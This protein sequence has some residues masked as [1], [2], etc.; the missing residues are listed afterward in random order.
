[1]TTER[2]GSFV[3]DR[4]LL[5]IWS[6]AFASVMWASS[7]ARRR[8]FSNFSGKFGRSL[9]GCPGYP[10]SCWTMGGSPSCSHLRGSKGWRAGGSHASGARCRR[11]RGSDAGWGSGRATSGGPCCADPGWRL[12]RTSGPRDST[13]VTSGSLIVGVRM[14]T[15]SF[16]GN[17]GFRWRLD[18]G[19]LQICVFSMDMGFE[20]AT[21]DC[22]LSIGG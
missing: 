13:G 14:F 11:P 1:V 8:L 21:L 12:S 20:Q 10:D 6:L 3:V 9:C 7:G 18:L 22:Y 15:I 4:S 5:T 17:Q 16:C 19:Y 2:L